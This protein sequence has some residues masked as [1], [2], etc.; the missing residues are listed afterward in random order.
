MAAGSGGIM[1]C[2]RNIVLSACSSSLVIEHCL[3]KTAMHLQYSPFCAAGSS[4]PFC[5]TWASITHPDSKLPSPGTWAMSE[6]SSRWKRSKSHPDSPIHDILTSTSSYCLLLAFEV[7]HHHFI[8]WR[9]L[10][11]IGILLF[12]VLHLRSLVDDWISEQCDVFGLQHLP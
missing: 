10:H 5:L 2:S 4:S 7:R 12:L 9:I 3:V 11:H 6:C 8:C 1:I